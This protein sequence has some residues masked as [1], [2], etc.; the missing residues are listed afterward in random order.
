MKHL[1]N[2]KYLV[3][4][5]GRSGTGF[6]ANLISTSKNC[7]HEAIF[8]DYGISCNDEL[9]NSE[10][11]SS[12]YAV[13]FI[14]QMDKSVKI[15]HIVRDPELVINSFY[16]MGVFSDNCLQFLTRGKY[17]KFFFR[18]F[19][20]PNKVI[21]RLKSFYRNKYF[22]TLFIKDYG[23]LTEIKRIER[24]WFTWNKMIESQ[25]R[26]NRNAYLRINMNEVEKK[27]NEID[28]FFDI[29]IDKSK[30]EFL[31]RNKK[32]FKRKSISFRLEKE[33]LDLKRLY[34]A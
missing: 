24:Y 32:N 14:S 29:K 15:L 4:G 5:A 7:G 18:V 13:P 27:I 26:N 23:H 28:N 31:D 30:L 16:K 1:K 34:F 3:V 11:E 12:F 17:L 9:N 8:N 2:I 21:K 6:M 33:T 25:V 10:Y 22:M 19:I 20:K